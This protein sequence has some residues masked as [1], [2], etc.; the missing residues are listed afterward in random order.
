MFSCK[1]SRPV[2]ANKACG[3]HHSA[4][5]VHEAGR[6]SSLAALSNWARCGLGR[7][8]QSLHCRPGERQDPY[9]ESHLWCSVVVAFAKR[10]PGLMGPGVR[11]D[12]DGEGLASS[13][14]VIVRLDR[15]IQY[16]RALG[17]LAEK[18]LEYWMPP[19]SRGMTTEK[20]R[21]L[22]L[23]ARFARALHHPSPSYKSEG[24]GRAGWP[25]HPGPRAKQIC[26]S[27]RTTGTGGDHTGA[28]CAM[29]YGLYVI[30]SVNLADCHRP[31]RDAKHHRQ[32]IG[33]TEVICPSGSPPPLTLA[34]SRPS[35]GGCV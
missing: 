7:A 24:A 6:G 18:S 4:Q 25:L 3:P 31:G 14:G 11:Q 10:H 5:V 35:A 19:L 12:D 23:A 21:V 28:P 26:A 9:R 27:A 33:K 1:L 13:L 22:V 2:V 32:V 17:A 20:T 30:S 16:S 29:V 34:S 8:R 15:T